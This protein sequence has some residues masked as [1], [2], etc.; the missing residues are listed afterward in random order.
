MEKKILIGGIAILFVVVIGII[1]LGITETER[2]TIEEA[3][4]ILAENIQNTLGLNSFTATGEGVIEVKNEETVLLRI[5]IEEMK[6]SIINPFDFANQDSSSTFRY[7]FLVNFSTIVAF[8]EKIKTPEELNEFRDMGGI[9]DIDLLANMKALGETNFS[10][11]METKSI[12]FDTYMNVVEITGLREI[13]TKVG[14]IFAAEMVTTMLEPHI[15]IWRKTP[16][17]Q[18][19]IIEATV[20]FEKLKNL[21]LAVLDAYYVKE[22]L[23][24]TEINKTSAYNFILGI[25]LDK[26]KDVVVSFVVPLL[27]EDVE[28]IEEQKRMATEINQNWPKIVKII[29]AAGIDSKIYISQ[30]DRLTIKERVL[31][32]IDLFEFMAI[33]EP[34]MRATEIEVTP[35]EEIDFAKMKEAVK[36]INIT[37]AMKVRYSNHNAVPNILPPA[38][39]KVIE[40]PHV[41]DPVFPTPEFIIPI[42]EVPIM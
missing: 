39:Y 25:D 9:F 16:A 27:M 24:N 12:D 8:I 15:G 19:N 10:V 21:M 35:E 40:I 6:S 17:D 36:N 2:P 13:A 18:A 5:A 14:G 3:N 38:E 26:L 30:E 23:V 33:L 22:A 20:M 1:G 41:L 37:M 28:N 42:P 4:I 31:V 29:E 32:E 7:S 11:T 34:I